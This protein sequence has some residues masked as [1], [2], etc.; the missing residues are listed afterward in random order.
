MRRIVTYF[1]LSRIKWVSGTV[2]S[3]A[4][5][6]Y[7]KVYSFWERWF[8]VTIPCPCVT[9]AFR[10]ST[11]LFYCMKGWFCHFK[12]STLLTIFTSQG[13]QRFVDILYWAPSSL[14]LWVHT[15]NEINARAGPSLPISPIKPHVD[16]VITPRTNAIVLVVNELHSRT[17]N[18]FY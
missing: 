5:T 6:C 15:L 12:Q 16:T 3:T 11:E 4:S 8:T 1:R 10:H 7:Q 17:L 18:G 13:A 9:G 14:L 2:L